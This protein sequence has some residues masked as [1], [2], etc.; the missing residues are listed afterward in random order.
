M[1]IQLG[2]VFGF[3][4]SQLNAYAAC[5]ITHIMPADKPGNK[6][7]Y[8]AVMLHWTGIELPSIEQLKQ[9]KPLVINF[10]FWGDDLDHVISGGPIPADY[11]YIGNLDVLA[12][13]M[14]RSYGDWNWGDKLYRQLQWE[15][16]PEDKRLN[17][18]AASKADYSQ[19]VEISGVMV[20]WGCRSLY[21]DRIP[22]LTDYKELDRLP[23]LTS[24]TLFDWNP[25]LESYIRTHHFIYKLELKLKA[26]VEQID[27]QHT[28]ITEMTI[29]PQNIQELLVP[30]EL[31][32]LTIEGSLQHNVHMHHE[33]EGRDI[34]LRL[35][36]GAAQSYRLLSG[37]THLSGLELCSVDDIDLGD[38]IDRFPSLQRLRIWGKP[39]YIRGMEQ[40]YRLKQLRIFTTMEMFGFSGE[41]FPEAHQLPQ[42]HTLWL[43]SLPADAAKTIKQAY[44]QAARQGL[45]LSI[46]Q[47]RKPE[48][49]A[50]NLD[51]PFRAWDGREGITAAQAKKAASL[52]KQIRGQLRELVDQAQKG[53]ISSEEVQQQLEY[54][55]TTY[56]EGFNKLDK[57]K[58]FIYTEEREE[59]FE[60]V[61]PALSGIVKELKAIQIEINE[62]ALW[63]YT[64]Q[65][66]D[67]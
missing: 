26:T 19:Q 55:F 17:F 30:N 11:T 41:Q 40:L 59:I 46:R 53:E 16:I 13:E 3:W 32:R 39:G 7:S 33:R 8:A 22:D 38:V 28:P 9:V 48:W 67:F 47:P 37:L 63:E 23:C 20:Q 2:D 65:L 64:D 43:T 58:V 57:R 61:T 1:E 54:I 51:N 31:E 35:N 18:K 36:D 29:N 5:Q 6:D 10:Y 66:R 52:Y 4:G 12:E 42:L 25:G 49:L 56:I 21:L 60:A 34:T 44:K 50:D 14:P 24:L 27:L 15:R 45:D 62:H